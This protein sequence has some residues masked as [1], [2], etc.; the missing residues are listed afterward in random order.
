MLHCVRWIAD[1]LSSSH[2]FSDGKLVLSVSKI[3]SEKKKVTLNRLGEWVS[4]V[5]VT[6][7]QDILFSVIYS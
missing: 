3:N 4:L 7:F 6:K 2:P 5:R 1:N